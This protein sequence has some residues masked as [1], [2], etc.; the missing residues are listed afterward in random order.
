[1]TDKDMDSMGLQ[2]IREVK[3]LRKTES[4]L[5]RRL[6]QAKEDIEDGLIVGSV[7]QML[8]PADVNPYDDLKELFKIRDR[9]A[10]NER[11]IVEQELNI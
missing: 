10:D 6:R 1:M 5:C 11:F 2:A 7:K 8:I 3:S 9:I 4:C